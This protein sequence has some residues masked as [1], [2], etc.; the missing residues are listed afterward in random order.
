[1]ILCI[2]SL[3]TTCP[4]TTFQRLSSFSFPLCV[5]LSFI[6]F[7]FLFFFFFAVLIFF[8]SLSVGAA[9]DGNWLVVEKMSDRLRV[10]G[11]AHHGHFE[12]EILLYHTFIYIRMMMLS[13]ERVQYCPTYTQRQGTSHCADVCMHHLPYYSIK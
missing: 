7:S 9:V 13:V 5:R 12:G 6:H 1:M 2:S 4:P 3:I 8:F 11:S 10:R